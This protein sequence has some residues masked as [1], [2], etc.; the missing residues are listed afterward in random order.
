MTDATELVRLSAREAVSLLR[1]GEVSPAE[2][3]EASIARIEAVDGAVNALPIRCWE[4]ARDHARRLASSGAGGEYERRPGWLAGLPI[5]IKDLMD[6]EGV[7]TTYGCH[8]YSDNVAT[9][10]DLL[11]RRLEAHGAIVVAKSNTPE[12]GML[13]VTDNR[14]F[15]ATRNPWNT[16]LTPGGSSGGAAA[17]VATG[18]VWLAH[19]SDIGGS[20][21]I[22]AAF[23]AT[24]GL[25][26]TPGRIARDHSKRSFSPMAVQ[27]PMARDVADLAL[28]LDAMAGFWHGDPLSLPDTDISWSRVVAEARPPRRVAFSADLGIG[29]TVNPEVAAIAERAA[30]TLE[31]MGTMVEAAHPDFSGAGLRYRTLV[32]MN[33]LVERQ[34][35]VDRHGPGL[36]PFMAG[37]IGHAKTFDGATVAAAERY[38][39]ELFTRCADFF[40]DWDLL[41]TPTL[42]EPPFPVETRGG[43]KV[44]EWAHTAPPAW[45]QQCWSTVIPGNPALSIPAGFTAAGL[46]VGLQ[47][48]GRGRDEAGILAAGALIEAALGLSARLPIDPRPA[49]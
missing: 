41:L 7:P 44:D 45:F 42:S 22:P 8:L 37:I 3:V 33:L 31:S 47:I 27:G 46:P 48:I 30:R 20:L 32:A 35:F 21:R 49:A 18:Q 29:G 34:E 40:E 1:R 16:A 28:F 25:R 12:F 15:G 23:T 26:P 10:S 38:R 11:V 6:V 13:P 2:L 39:A 19:G 4:R 43:Y 17:A 9:R 24:C 14:V 36:E 5:A